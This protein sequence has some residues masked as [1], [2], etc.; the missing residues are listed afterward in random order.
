[1]SDASPATR[2]DLL[3]FARRV[4]EQQARH[5]LAQIDRWISDEERRQVEQENAAARRPPIPDWVIE[6]GLNARHSV[7]VHVGGCPTAGKRCKAATE[8]QARQ[9]LAAG[10]DACPHCR[11]D[12]ALGVLD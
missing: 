11:P 10:V 12:T 3:R 5:Q 4:V 2:L 1:M 6:R 7:Y 8:G 9:A